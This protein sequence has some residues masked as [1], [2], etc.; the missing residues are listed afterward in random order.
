MNVDACALQTFQ[1]NNNDGHIVGVVGK[2]TTATQ[3]A[4]L[5]DNGKGTI[6]PFYACIRVGLW[7]M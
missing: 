7:H 2:T 4:Q 5:Y 3:A 1:I 6:T